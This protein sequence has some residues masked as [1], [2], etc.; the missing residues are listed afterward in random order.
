MSKKSRV[1][2]LDFYRRRQY[3]VEDRL[4]AKEARNSKVGIFS[5]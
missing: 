1:V 5:L 2:Y 3:D 4:E